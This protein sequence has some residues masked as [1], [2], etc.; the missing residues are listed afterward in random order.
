M[1]CSVVV[2]SSVH[3]EEYVVLT[4]GQAFRH[5]SAKREFSESRIPTA[6]AT[7]SSGRSAL[8]RIAWTTDTEGVAREVEEGIRFVRWIAGPVTHAN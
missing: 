3:V 1:C 7:I 2:S 8:V 6:S 5:C 4:K